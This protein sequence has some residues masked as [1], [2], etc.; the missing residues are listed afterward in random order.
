[1][2]IDKTK[3]ELL[4][5]LT[6]T[7]KK[8]QELDRCRDEYEQARTKYE[9]LLDSTPDAMLFVNAENRIVLINAQFEKVFGYTQDEVIG[10][11]LDIL[12]PERYRKAHNRKVEN[13]FKQPRV[14]SMGA[15]LEIYGHRKDGQEFPADISL[16]PLQTDEE[17]L[18]A[19]AVRDISE[20]KE[21]EA[22]I[23]LNYYIQKVTNSM[24][25][26]SLEPLSLEEQFDRVLE[27]ILNV[28]NLSLQSKGAIFLKNPDTAILTLKAQHGFSGDD[29]IPCNEIPFGHCL[30]GKAAAMSQLVY[31]EDIDG[32]HEI[33][34][35][36]MY[37]HGHYC[38]PIVSG[39][40]VYG[41]LN[42]YI[43]EGH[44]RSNREEDFLT[45]VTSTLAA[46]IERDR[47]E[48]EKKDLQQQ[49]A[50]AEKLAALGRF[51]ANVAHEIRNPLTSVGGFARRLDKTLPEE[52]KEK[53]YAKII[54]AEVMRLEKILK[55][56]LS[57]SKDKPLNFAENDLAQVIEQ[58]LLMNEDLFSGKN[59]AIK[60]SFAT[61]P[62][63]FFDRD[64]LIEVLEN[65]LLNA[66][67][68]MSAGGT[69]AISTAREEGAGKTGAVIKIA[70]T[71]AGISAEQLK[72]IFE[73]FYTTKVAEQGTGL[74]LSITRKIMESLGG[75]V[76]ITSEVGKGTVVILSL[77]FR[78]Q[79]SQE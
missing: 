20:R 60:K 69:L 27:L 75:S 9:N 7:R 31:A 62:R 21:A 15:N 33:H 73:P 12:I 46:I 64:M 77:P 8:V 44:E 30:C 78:Q 40:K 55:N 50:Q 53:G 47:M 65:I 74:G 6:A 43:R 16:S 24:L 51:T 11:K 25:R 23:E 72:M 68:S 35:S 38:V 26:I 4:G 3:S 32:I 28:P 59:I 36:E 63:F 39:N 5:E 76:E 57:F 14:R 13:F 52:S 58:A 37:P 34:D 49:L 61:M 41:L 17:L 22:Q 45:S 67:E 29:A 1:M 71:G 10:R 48:R 70:D 42:V 19:A 56:I 54:I 2:K 79:P 66:I 18:V